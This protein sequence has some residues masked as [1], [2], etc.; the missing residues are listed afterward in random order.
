M[1]WHLKLR[2]TICVQEAFGKAWVL[3]DMAILAAMLVCVISYSIYIHSLAAFQPQDTYPVYDSLGG[4]QARLLLPKKQGPSTH[5]GEIPSVQLLSR[6]LEGCSALYPHRP[7]QKE[8]RDLPP[9]ELSFH[10]H[11]TH[12]THK[13][14]CHLS[15]LTLFVHSGPAMT[16]A[17]LSFKL[18]EWYC[19]KPRCNVSGR[20]HV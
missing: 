12:W 18:P 4:A 3:Y 11:L 16:P 2:H 17:C 15:D 14:G 10:I 5:N 1:A 7:M 13:L 9:S 20:G 8:I 19:F 6:L